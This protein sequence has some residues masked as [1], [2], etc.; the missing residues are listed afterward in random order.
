[1]YGDYK[2]VLS[3]TK[4]APQK[5]KIRFNRFRKMNKIDIGAV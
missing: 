1:V 2:A 4:A 3:N 5:K